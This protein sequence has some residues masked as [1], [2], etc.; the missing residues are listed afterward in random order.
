MYD[1]TITR[2]H[3]LTRWPWL[4]SWEVYEGDRP[5]LC[6]GFGLAFSEASAMRQIRRTIENNK[7]QVIKKGQIKDENNKLQNKPSL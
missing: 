5:H 7:K 1:Y 3:G 2:N 6:I 4:Y